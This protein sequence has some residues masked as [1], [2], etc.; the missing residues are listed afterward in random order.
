MGEEEGVGAVGGD[1]EQARVELADP[2]G[3]QLRGA[4]RPLVDV[5]A[6]V[7][8][9]EDQGARGGEEDA[10]VIGDAEP[11]RG[12]EGVA[13]GLRRF[14][15]GRVAGGAGEL[16][17]GRPVA[18]DLAVAGVGPGQR[19]A[20]GEDRVAAARG[21]LEVGG[22]ALFGGGEGVAHHR[23]VGFER[24]DELRSMPRPGRRRGWARRRCPRRRRA[25]PARGSRGARSRCAT[26]PPPAIARASQLAAGPIEF[27]WSPSELG[28]R[29]AGVVVGRVSR[30]RETSAIAVD[31][32]RVDV[33]AR[34]GV[35]PEQAL[36]EVKKTLLPSAVMPVVVD[37]VG[38][39]RGEVDAARR[40]H[41]S[42]CRGARG[43]CRWRL[44]RPCW[45]TIT[46]EPSSERSSCRDPGPGHRLPQRAS[47][48]RRGSSR[49]LRSRSRSRCRRRCS[50]RAR[51]GALEPKIR[52]VPS[53]EKRLA[54]WPSGSA[55]GS[56]VE[57]AGHPLDQAAVRAGGPG[58]R[59]RS[60]R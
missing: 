40:S 38:G 28:D 5:E 23:V 45:A 10:A 8:V 34:V 22:P 47:S 17:V 57:R 36:L 18:V 39:A 19:Q 59:S 60:L 49:L 33:R 11:V 15:A 9:V 31:V 43:R 16:A 25:A 14:A 24:G 27:Q 58:S 46:R 30:R 55:A 54:T 56:G 51:T 48:R 3:D 2:R 37:A 21:G 52:W 44:R 1:R 50:R 4:L 35:G 6:A 41:R 12:E 53:A 13:G 7:G 26:P 29:V 32:G 20:R 42:S